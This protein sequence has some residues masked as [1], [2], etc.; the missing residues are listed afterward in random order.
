M[1]KNIKRSAAIAAAVVVGGA[2]LA[3][4][5]SAATNTDVRAG[6]FDAARTLTVGTPTVD[7]LREGI[8]LQSPDS[9]SYAVGVFD[10]TA[11]INLADVHSAVGKWDGTD[12]RPSVK[13]N[14]DVDGDGAVDCQLQVERAYGDDTAYLNKDTDSFKGNEGE[15]DSALADNYCTDNSPETKG[16]PAQASLDDWATSLSASPGA[17]GH[18]QVIQAGYGVLS[19]GKGDGVLESISLG[20]N[21]YTFSSEEAATPPGQPV[22]HDTDSHTTVGIPAGGIIIHFN[23]DQLPPGTLQGKTVK[24]VVTVD[25]DR[26]FRIHQGSGDPD[27]YKYFGVRGETHKVALYKNSDIGAT[28][29]R[30]YTVR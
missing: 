6:D 16:D 21:K 27:Y 12:S 23:A 7:F 29:L 3:A 10:L 24:W 30:T 17:V 19:G 20:D 1:N 15:K 5:A 28:P 8:H 11:P 18:T 22:V 25:G 9:D 2:G 26:V 14:L 4:S 13:L